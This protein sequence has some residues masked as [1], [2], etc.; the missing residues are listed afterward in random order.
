MISFDYGEK[1]NKILEEYSSL[2][3][4]EQVDYKKFYLYSLITHSTAIEGS[5]ITELENQVLFDEGISIKGK[6]MR[7]QLMNLDLKNAYER[8]MKMAESH[9][10]YSIDMLKELAALVMKNTGAE[11]NTIFGNFDASK[12]DL[13]LVG[14]TA[15]VG[16]RSYMDFRKVPDRLQKLC[17]KI[18]E[19]RNKL[20]NNGSIIEK[21]NVS[22]DAHLDLV[23]IHPWVDG[24]GRTSRMVMNQL[25][26]E[27]GLVPV[28]IIK[29]DRVE[30][31]E[32]LEASREEDSYEPFRRFMYE[33]HIR[34]LENELAEYKKSQKNDLIK[35][36]NDLIN[37]KNDHHAVAHA[38][39][40]GIVISGIHDVTHVFTGIKIY[41]VFT[42]KVFLLDLL[43]PF[44]CLLVGY[45]D[46]VKK[47]LISHIHTLF[48]T[49]RPITF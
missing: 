1:L 21:Y 15:G 11:Y 20:L 40:S 33:E 14:V 32:A 38:F 48:R 47:I 30:Y 49:P 18:N 23:T 28:K 9:L 36:K 6:N 25:Q 10:N 42:E 44:L 24:N 12:G 13:R 41:F 19:C 46:L 8:S 26:Y 45:T 27:M 37:Q 16:G 22:F 4:A 5:T 34:N 3:I 39:G 2:G 17:D 35:V 7:E 43:K 31:I 29:E